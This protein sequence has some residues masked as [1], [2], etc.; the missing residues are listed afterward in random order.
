MSEIKVVDVFPFPVFLLPVVFR[1]VV[2]VQ[3]QRDAK[4]RTHSRHV[5][6][7]H[8]ME[9]MRK[10]TMNPNVV[11]P[12]FFPIQMVELKCSGDVVG[13]IGLPRC[14]QSCY[15]NSSQTRTNNKKNR[16]SYQKQSDESKSYLKKAVNKLVQRSSK[17]WQIKQSV[18]F[19]NVTRFDIF[20]SEVNVSIILHIKN[21]ETCKYSN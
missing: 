20:Y 3:W 6:F 11:S 19:G 1:F 8:G 9:T 2:A 13:V 21:I 18:H 4:R 17:I 15:R 5:G 14:T 7:S 10:A 12:H 16:T